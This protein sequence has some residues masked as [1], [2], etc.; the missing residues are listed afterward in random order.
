[1][2][3]SA[4]RSG[5]VFEIP[6]EYSNKEIGNK[7]EDFELLEKLGAGGYGYAIKVRSL[8]NFKMYVI[9]RSIKLTNEDKREILYLL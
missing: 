4:S 3:V 5:F 6:N 7:L 9:K 2:G 8:K 1:M